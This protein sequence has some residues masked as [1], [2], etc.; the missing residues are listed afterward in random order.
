MVGVVSAFSDCGSSRI[1]AD[2]SVPRVREL[3]K[4][5]RPGLEFGR[6]ESN[7]KRRIREQAKVRPVVMRDGTVGRVFIAT[8]VRPTRY[9][10]VHSLCSKPVSPPM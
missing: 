6:I 3:F 9:V 5:D 1:S 2:D 7:A 8:T 4:G 10:R